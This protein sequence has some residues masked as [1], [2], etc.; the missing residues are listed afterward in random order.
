MIDFLEENAMAVFTGLAALGGTIVGAAIQTLGGHLQAQGARSAAETTAAA[1][2][3]AVREQVERTA[4]AASLA[5]LR[6]QQNAAITDFLR[7]IR[8]F[9]RAVDQWYRE[10]SGRS[11]EAAHDELAHAHA[12]L[13]LVAQA[14]LGPL[15]ARIIATVEDWEDLA[16]DRAPACR[17]QRVIDAVTGN[18]GDVHGTGTEASE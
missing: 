17:A 13:I 10:D 9:T 5:A 6:E 3:G 12:R 18:S 1:T 16:R 15:T 14:G 4:E 7:A 8:E 2:I 11:S